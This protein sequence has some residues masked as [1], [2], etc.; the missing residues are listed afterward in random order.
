MIL[1]ALFASERSKFTQVKTQERVSFANVHFH[2]SSGTVPV[3]IGPLFYNCIGD[4]VRKRG[5]Q[6]SAD[7]LLQ[8]I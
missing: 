5:R 6:E 1:H 4:S 2:T 7:S 8:L 3:R